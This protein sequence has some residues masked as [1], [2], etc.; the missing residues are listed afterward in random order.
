MYRFDKEKTR[1][2]GLNLLRNE[3][4]SEKFNLSKE[5]VLHLLTNLKKA[6]KI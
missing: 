1:E 3:K 2:I 5:S 6:G 4:I